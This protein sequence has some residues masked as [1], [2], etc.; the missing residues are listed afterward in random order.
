M[1][2]NSPNNL[3]GFF[4]V[5]ILSCSSPSHKIGFS[6]DGSAEPLDQKY[7]VERTE[8]VEGD[9]VYRKYFEY[10]LNGKLQDLAPNPKVIWRQSLPFFEHD[11]ITSE[12]LVFLDRLEYQE[13]LTFEYSIGEDG[14][15]IEL[16]NWPQVKSF[17]DS[18]SQAYVQHITEGSD[19]VDIDLL[20]EFSD[21]FTTQANIEARSAREIQLVHMLYGLEFNAGD[22]SMEFLSQTLNMLFPVSIELTY[23]GIG[24]S[25]I[26]Y[27]SHMDSVNLAACFPFIV[28]K[29]SDLP[30]LEYKHMEVFDSCVFVFDHSARW[31]SEINFWRTAQLDSIRLYSTS[32]ITMNRHSIN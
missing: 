3:V 11:S 10:V 23:H 20:K 15:L 30:D 7:Y 21:A 26:L 13:G 32:T 29:I 17:V 6:I 5:V 24:T 31:P 4:L 9:T 25:H 1:K 8:W 2:A 12:D 19:T 22:S 16:L 28:D 27:T 18:M 14:E